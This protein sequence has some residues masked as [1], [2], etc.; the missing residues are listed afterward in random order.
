MTTAGRRTRLGA[1]LL[2]LMIALGIFG[3]LASIG[4]LSLRSPPARLVANGVQAAVQQARFDAIRANRPMVVEIDAEARL[5][6]V[7]SAVDAAT[8]SCVSPTPV[9]EVAFAGDGRATVAASAFPIVW[10][11]SGQP[12]TCVGTPFTLAGVSVDVSDAYRTLSVVVGAG[13][14]VVVR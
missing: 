13:G 7:S 5:V 3:I 8:V 14:E 4:G 10:L 9:R 1:T 11:P 12:R 2:E 6:R